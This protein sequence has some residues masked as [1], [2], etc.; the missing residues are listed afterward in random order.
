MAAHR[1]TGDDVVRAY[2][3]IQDPKLRRVWK[4][5]FRVL[6]GIPLDRWDKADKEK[7]EKV[8]EA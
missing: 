8:V 3:H 1:I 7:R 2:Q 4:S 5:A 6:W